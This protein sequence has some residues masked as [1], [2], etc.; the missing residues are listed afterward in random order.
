MLTGDK[1]ETAENIGYACKLLKEDMHIY[2]LTN[3][4]ETRSF[5]TKKTL[6][7]NK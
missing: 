1:A 7:E 3:S 4:K 5:C 6:D 2:Y